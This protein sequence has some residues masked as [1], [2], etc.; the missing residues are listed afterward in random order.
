MPLPP[1]R[2][3]SCVI[4]ERM[5]KNKDC[6]NTC[7]HKCK[8][9]DV[10]FSHRRFTDLVTEL[11]YNVFTTKLSTLMVF[12]LCQRLWSLWERG[13]WSWIRCRSDW[14]SSERISTHCEKIIAIKAARHKAL[15]IKNSSKKDFR[16]FS[17]NWLR[18]LKMPK[19]RCELNWQ[20][21]EYL[22]ELLQSKL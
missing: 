9:F 4:C 18:N 7:F 3:K 20:I 15:R 5:G 14:S 2:P 16:E 8:E 17:K 1:L 10:I 19:L 13:V 21:W 12:W 6:Y 11:N 22:N